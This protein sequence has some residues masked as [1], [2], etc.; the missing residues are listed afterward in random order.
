MVV[1][2]LR[3]RRQIRGTSNCAQRRR[4]VTGQKCEPIVQPCTFILTKQAA[5]TFN[6]GQQ[7][8]RLCELAQIR[9]AQG[10]VEQRRG[11]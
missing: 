6:D 7:R 11:E 9:L 4:V 3:I 1:R 10:A 2:G 5:A 8:F